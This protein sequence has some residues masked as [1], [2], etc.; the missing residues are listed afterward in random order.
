MINLAMLGLG[1]S[2]LQHADVAQASEIGKVNTY[3][4][5]NSLKTNQ[6]LEL[7]KNGKTTKEVGV[8]VKTETHSQASKS[9]DTNKRADSNQASRLLK[10]NQNRIVDPKTIKDDWSLK[11]TKVKN[12]APITPKKIHENQ[13]T[14][15]NINFINSEIKVKPNDKTDLQ[16][17][18]YVNKDNFKDYFNQN[19]SAKG[20]YNPIT[21]E[22]KLTT[23][24]WQSGNITFK[25]GIDL[26]HN[27]RIDGA[28]NLGKETK[29]R[30]VFRVIK[31]IADGIGIVFYKGT[32]NQIG[33][34][35]GNLGIYG[36]T[37]A[38]GWKADTWHNVGRSFKFGN[39]TRR[40]QGEADDAFPDPYGAMVTT[41]KNGQGT[42]DKD[43][44]RPLPKIIE[45]NKYHAIKM[46]YTA[47]TKEFKVILST[48][49]GDVIF[50]K[51]F[52]YD[53]KD[54]VYYF[55]I[56]S[57]T[58]VLPTKQF[59][60]IDS[61]KYTSI[62][63]AFIKYIDDNTGTNMRVR[64]LTGQGGKTMK[65]STRADIQDYLKQ[66]YQLVS[67]NFVTG[68]TFDTDDRTDQIYEV[69]FKHG[70]ESDFEKRN[71]KE[72]VHYRYDNGQLAR[73]IYQNVLN[74][75][76]KVE[77][78]QVTKQRN[79]KNWQAVDG[80][81]FKRVV[82]PYIKG[83]TA[84]PKL[85]D[86]ITNINEN[87]KNIEK[88]VVYKA[89]DE[90]AQVKYFDDTTG[91]KLSEQFLHGAYGSRDVYR[92]ANT[93]Q[94]YKQ[95]GYELVSDNYPKN[96]AK[97]SQDKLVRVYEIHLKHKIVKQSEKSTLKEV[98]HYL[99]NNGHLAK[100]VYES[101]LKFSR[102]VGIDQVTGKKYYGIWQATEGTS[103]KKVVSPKIE[104]YTAL[105]K[106]VVAINNI[107]V[108]HANIEKT[109]VYKANDE[110]ARVKYFDDTIGRKLSEQLLHGVYGSR[111]VYR[112]ANTIQRYKQMGYELVS[113]N[114]PKNGANYSQDKLVRVYE[115]HLKHKIVKQPEKSTVKEVIHYLYDN[116]QPAGPIY[117]NE[118]DFKR[119]IEFDQVTKQ[120]R[121]GNWQAIDGTYFK[122][123]D[124]PK[125]IGYT[126]TL[127]SIETINNID[128]SHKDIEE[129]VVYKINDEKA[130]VTY[131]DD[132]TRKKLSEKGLNG[133]YRTRDSYRTVDAI[134]QYKW[135]GYELVSDD[136]PQNGVFYDQDKLIK[137]YEVHL[138]HG[139]KMDFEQRAVKE[140]IYYQYDDGQLAKPTYK[141]KLTFR[142]IVKIDQ[143]T[144]QKYYGV[145]QA[146][147]GTNFRSVVSPIVEGYT[148][149]PEIVR[150]IN[151]INSYHQDVEKTV[152]YQAN[153]QNEVV[154]G[155]SPKKFEQIK[156][157]LVR[158]IHPNREV[159]INT[160]K[161]HTKKISL[162]L[163]HDRQK[164]ES[165]HKTK[166]KLNTLIKS[167][168][169]IK[170]Q[171]SVHQKRVIKKH[172]KLPQTGE[173]KSNKFVYFLLVPLLI[174]ST[175]ITIL[176][177]K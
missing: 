93:I 111:D 88:I 86:E 15:K 47:R 42:I 85:I 138:K 82:S 126:P 33:R 166:F 137:M 146:V 149:I 79:Y 2:Y 150:A 104:G 115:I 94:R 119:I 83:Y 95:M 89:N 78:D 26:R 38:F 110:K 54:P 69:H 132:T 66:G 162:K 5:A 56:A 16:D 60:K 176:K 20:N 6:L 177:R 172:Q 34:S 55:T 24:S 101:V 103:F 3:K 139:E 13:G 121:Y 41:N 72:T 105:P 92:T 50:K 31:G 74:F 164:V 75:E 77:T 145:W 173:K 170:K 155:N 106:V 80:T 87:H 45:D 120:K 19:G 134:N 17:N 113:D 122:K 156:I 8:D 30:N 140:V 160:E 129:T 102:M 22:Q 142:R 117:E 12:R 174:L 14:I 9:N 7:T 29:V 63:K 163:H 107:N 62:Q 141:N 52:D 127:E 48:P 46:I 4:N 159:R 153:K 169:K 67:D 84:V 124:S 135:A 73:P 112:T 114:Y 1:I 37:N 11:N 130:Q 76:R 43:S 96:G 154:G 158:V 10:K 108:N 98:I 25:G 128:G 39:T 97:Y 136:Y 35:G 90:K 167:G 151:N 91:R 57:S 49:T 40:L 109:V 147:D 53:A 143:V 23:G 125:I 36:V 71:V 157:I 100:P 64:V 175:I 59:F 131:Y 18:V 165:T 51:K 21:G 161:S 116:G 133:A 123:V 65:Y 152:V 144:G 70:I 44:V 68:T 118:L 99:Y 28:I 81:S 148:P 58:G 168:D 32:R 27:F 61:M 171:N